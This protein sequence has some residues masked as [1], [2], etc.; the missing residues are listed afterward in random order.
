MSY[1]CSKCKEEITKKEYDYSMKN[2]SVALCREHQKNNNSASQPNGLSK[3]DSNY[4]ESM[5]FID[6]EKLLYITHW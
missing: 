1:E 5:M 2:F 3:R 4:K 6:K